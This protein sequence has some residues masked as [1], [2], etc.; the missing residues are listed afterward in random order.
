MNN[1]KI[2]V[3]G[4][5]YVGLTFSIS[6]A[7]KNF[8][9][10][11]YEIDNNTFNT[12]S[13]GKAQFYEENINNDLK[14][15]LKNKKIKL[16]Q[17]LKN[18]GECNVIFITVGTP[19]KETKKVNLKKLFNL[20]NN[21]KDKLE[22]NTIVALRS[23]VKLGTTKKIEK[24]LNKNKK[25]NLAMCPERTAEG[26]ALKEIH[27]LPQVIGAINIFT[28]NKLNKIFKKITKTTIIFNSY[29]EA[30]ILKL[31]DNSY[32][33]TIFGF[34]NELASISEYYKINILNVISKIGIKY[35]RSK[36]AYP[37]T[38]GGPCL[39]KDSHLLIESVKKK[40]KLNIIKSARKINEDLPLKTINIVKKK[41]Q[42]PVKKILFCGLAF[43]GVPETSDTRGSMAN[44]IINTCRKKF[45][46]SEI[47]ALDN[48]VSIEDALAIYGN[49]KF[50]KEFEKINRKFDLI[51]ILNNNPYWK[52]IGLKNLKKKLNKEGII[53]DFWSS[54]KNT[55]HEKKY[56]K[57]GEGKLLNKEEI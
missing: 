30:E 34:A 27:L 56:F 14:K 5:G 20:I 38:V 41:V 26:S 15:T 7:K 6:L 19:I 57:F 3:I 9:V 46:K 47:F 48:F 53:F 33:D 52:K 21:L 23:T 36:V 37:G 13:K 29:E 1:N 43:K 10:Y 22:E 42:W 11:G 31:I 18:I 28:K 35:P 49:I 51:F 44:S 54:F 32:R 24:I 2:G 50:K 8:E 55:T 40:V 4:L 16:F 12:I 45:K 39:T 17:N 25:I